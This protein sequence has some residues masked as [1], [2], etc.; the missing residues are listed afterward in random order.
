VFG[1]FTS[2]QAKADYTYRHLIV[3]ANVIGT[4]MR[5]GQQELLQLK[6]AVFLH[7]G[8]I[9]FLNFSYSYWERFP[10]K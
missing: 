9:I 4:W 7:P 8:S 6:N 1:L 3:V 10:E 2:I 5:L